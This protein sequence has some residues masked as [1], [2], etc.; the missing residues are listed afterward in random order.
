MLG[1]LRPFGVPIFAFTDEEPLFR[2]LMLPWGVE[3]FLIE[4]ADDPEVT[5]QTS[6]KVLAEKGWTKNGQW[7]VVITNALASDQIIDTLQLR[8]VEV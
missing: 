7:L 8:Q 6:M 5:I 1:A 2:Q 4:F 3:P